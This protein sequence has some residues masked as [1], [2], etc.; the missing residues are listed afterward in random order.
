M[1]EDLVVVGRIRRSHGVYGVVVVEPMTASAEEV[2][3]PEDFTDEQRRGIVQLVLDK[4]TPPLRKPGRYQRG[5][6]LLGF[7]NNL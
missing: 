6:R 5:D 2:F 4:T 7:L 1:P 3:T